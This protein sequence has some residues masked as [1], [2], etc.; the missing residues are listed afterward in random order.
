MRILHV[1]DT[2]L[3]A[4]PNGLLSRAR[5]V[6]EAFKESIDIAIEERVQLY[7]HSGDFFDSPNPPPE[8]YI[9]A[10]R[11]LKKLK[12]HGIK[13]IVIAGQHDIPKRYAS[14]PLFLLSDVGT[15]DI[16]AVDK[17]IH[18]SINIDGSELEIVGVPYSSRSSISRVKPLKK[19]SILVAHLLLKE[20]GI[21]SEEADISINDFP[22]GFSYIALGDYHIK[23][24]YR[25]SSG[26]PIV[27][28]GATE[29]F[30][31]NECCDK[32]V[33]IADIDNR[34]VDIN[35][36][37]IQSVRPWIIIECRDLNTFSER[38][39]QS[40]KEL[41]L[42]SNKKPPIVIVNAYNVKVELIAKI[43]DGLKLK[44]VIEY[45]R[46]RAEGEDKEIEMHIPSL[47]NQYDMVSIDIV[48]KKIIQD[49]KLVELLS[50][51]IKNPDRN[52]MALLVSYLRENPEVAKK[53][54][55]LYTRSI[56]SFA[57]NVDT[58]LKKDSN[59]SS[60]V[61]STA[62]KR[63]ILSYIG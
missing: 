46:I 49:D 39:Q 44:R 29:I 37:K 40:I 47:E 43:L 7:I 36:I 38:L 16:L 55:K 33:A 27:Y 19:P 26:T 11:N 20:I 14:T 45:Y 42:K 12:D 48:L 6:Y 56:E 24:V 58:D 54:E 9:V 10:Y 50:N 31:V 8:A 41:S 28:P 21:P 35:F 18:T 32:Y 57:L 51:F 59:R 60:E 30:K 25:H 62:G 4:M 63:G 1:S 23:S 2:H 22:D 13:V 53:L 61:R 52:T 5:D 34:N 17:P 3:G 15:I